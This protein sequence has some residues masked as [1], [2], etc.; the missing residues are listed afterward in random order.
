[1][2]V[3]I[4]VILEMGEEFRANVLTGHGIASHVKVEGVGVSFEQG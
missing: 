1:M 4:K 3:V 2:V